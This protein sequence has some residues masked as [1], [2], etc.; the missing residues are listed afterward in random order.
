VKTLYLETSAAFDLFFEKNEFQKIFTLIENQ[1]R[2][3]TSIL[4]F[5]EIRRILS[6]WSVGKKITESQKFKIF[7]NTERISKRWEVMEVSPRIQSRIGEKFPIEPV[8]T[9]D[10]IHLASALEFTQSFPELKILSFDRRILDNLEPLGL[11][12]VSL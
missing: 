5:W 2:V 10:A 1:E 9:L 12:L 7:G 6:R 8:R 3:V 11:E 4:T